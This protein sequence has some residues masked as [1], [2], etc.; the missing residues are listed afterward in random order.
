MRTDALD[1][2]S[3]LPF[4]RPYPA[5]V[6]IAETRKGVHLRSVEIVGPYNPAGSAHAPSRDRILVCQPQSPSQETSCARTILS[7]L[8]RRAYRRPVAP[9]DLQPL[10]AA[11]S[12]GRSGATFDEGLEQAVMRLLMSP[13][14][15]FRVERDPANVAGRRRLR[16]QPVRAGIAAV[17]FLWAASRLTIC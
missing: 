17:I 12:D 3:R 8:A 4:E 5:G 16:R 10:M 9:A 2:T 6:N 13:E 14:F 1:E 7:T 11:Y 15:L